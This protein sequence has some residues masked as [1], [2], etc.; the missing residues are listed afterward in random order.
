VLFEA[1]YQVTQPFDADDESHIYWEGEVP[2]GETQTFTFV[3]PAEEG[4]YQIVCG[5]AGH[6]EAG[7]IGVF[8]VR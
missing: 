4:V 3:A 7:M 6:A 5:V 8:T 1:G 2:P